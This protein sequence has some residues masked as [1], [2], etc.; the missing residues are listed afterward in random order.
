MRRYALC[1]SLPLMLVLV[2]LSLLGGVGCEGEIS[3]DPLAGGGAGVAEPG[4]PGT[5]GAA[6]PARPP[7]EGDAGALPPATTADGGSTNDGAGGVDA[8]APAEDGGATADGGN[9]DGSSGPPPG[10]A[11][12]PRA[13]SEPAVTSG[14]AESTVSCAG[15]A[16]VYG[17]EPGGALRAYSRRKPG[18]ADGS[19]AD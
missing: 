19:W 15:T 3:G 1:R 5:D 14:T 2:V 11:P 10:P 4:L 18:A 16:T 9:L 17:L 12:I 13:N 7:V 6:S 8:A